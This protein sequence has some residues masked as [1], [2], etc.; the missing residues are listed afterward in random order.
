MLQTPQAA[1]QAPATSG[2]Q[3]VSKKTGAAYGKHNF[4]FSNEVFEK[5][6]LLQR[7]TGMAQHALLD[8]IITRYID[9]YEAKF[10]KLEKDANLL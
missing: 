3:Y 9:E 10:G 6:K 8:V 5:L 4:A 2:S 1:Q 7:K